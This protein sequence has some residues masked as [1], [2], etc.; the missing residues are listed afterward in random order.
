MQKTSLPTSPEYTF[1][2]SFVKCN[3]RLHLAVSSFF[4]FSDVGIGSHVRRDTRVGLVCGQAT[5]T[6]ELPPNFQ[7]GLPCKY[8]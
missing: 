7:V 1:R 2:T 6:V 3:S 8:E 4:L 5:T